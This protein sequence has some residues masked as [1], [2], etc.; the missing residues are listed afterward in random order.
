MPSWLGQ[1]GGDRSWSFMP[2]LPTGCIKHGR[3]GGKPSCRG[4]LVG[5]EWWDATRTRVFL[6]PGAPAPE[7]RCCYLALCTVHGFLLQ[8]RAPGHP[9]GTGRREEILGVLQ[10]AWRPQKVNHG[11]EQEGVAA[12]PHQAVV[13]VVVW[14]VRSPRSQ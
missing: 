7:A 11:P 3:L 6:S 13:S 8:D 1:G 14:E 10:P 12:C 5:A 2:K 9:A 4:D